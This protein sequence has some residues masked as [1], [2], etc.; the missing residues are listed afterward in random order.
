MTRE[1]PTVALRR[2]ARIR[3]GSDHS[4]VQADDGSYPVYGSGG[5]FAQATDWLY[6]GPAVLLGRKGTIDRPLL[7]YGK[8]WTV[9]TMFCVQPLPAVDERYLYY[10]A[11]TIPF[12]LLSTSTALPSMTQSDLKAVRLPL[13]PYEHQRVIADFL[14]RETAQIDELIGK[15]NALIKLLG[16]RRKAVVERAVTKGL[17]PTAPMKP[18]GALWLGMVP[19]HWSVLP[20]G[21]LYREVDNRRGPGSDLPL[22]SVSIHRG[23]LPR[24]EMGYDKEP[25]ADDMSNYKRVNAGD[26]VLNRMRAFQGG[27]G[28]SKQAGIV[29]PD[30]MVIRP[31]PEHVTGHFLASLMRTGWF[32]EHMASRLRGIGTVDQGNAR[33][34]RI[35][36][37]DLAGIVVAV[38][39]LSE[40]R[41]IGAAVEK[42]MSDLDSLSQ[43]A[44]RAV[45]LLRERRS[46]LITAAVTGK[47]DVRGAA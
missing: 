24:D 41:S 15:Q 18:S 17:E 32:V 30:Y 21:R 7:A 46:A 34:P 6:S 44:T 16:E 36:P 35:N 9:D 42:Q 12:D 1:P 23:V 2:L 11:T 39:P 28:E 37:G 27:L 43:L 19:E 29:S 8:F 20:V 22:L 10:A 4:A 45:E 31:R 5:V 26:V 13:H 3:N 40:Q 14:D 47:I 25:R 33:T 38:P